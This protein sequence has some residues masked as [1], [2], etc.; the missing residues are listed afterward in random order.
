MTNLDF[1]AQHR[2]EDVRKL[3]LKKVPEGVDIAFCL[4]QIEGWQLA[5]KK[6]PEWAATDGLLFPPRLS[7][8]Q[9]SSQQTALYKRGW[10]SVCWTVSMIV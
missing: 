4:Q 9:C 8:E 3:A 10:W 7:M 5:R 6:I 1:I 2:T